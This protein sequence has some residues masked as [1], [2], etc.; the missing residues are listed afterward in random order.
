MS[1]ISDIIAFGNRTSTDLLNNYI[2]LGLKASGEYGESL[3]SKVIETPKGYKI[4]QF[5][6]EQALWMEEGRRP[7]QDQSPEG[8]KKAARQ[9]YPVIIEWAQ[10]K[11]LNFTNSRSYLTARK[12][13][14]QGWQVPNNHNAGGVISDVI[15]EGWL[16]E[17][18]KVAGGALLTELTSDILTRFKKME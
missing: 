13:V 7:N 9:L 18:A 10:N 5:G 17:G 4:Q 16:R 11:G 15:N 14:M 8:I 12:I 6:A 3:E 1:T 2:K